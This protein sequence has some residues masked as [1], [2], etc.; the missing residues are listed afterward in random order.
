MMETAPG[1]RSRLPLKLDAFGA[2]DIGRK[3]KHNEDAVLLRPDLQL[4]VLADG[5]G[6]HNAGNV[7]SALA[8][9]SVANFFE[10][11]EE[12]FKALPLIDQF[13]LSVG[14]R[15]L[16]AAVQRAN[17]DIIDIS[18][19][20]NKHKGMGSTVVA[21]SISAAHGIAH[22]AHVGDSPCY[23]I[24]G[25]ELEQLTVDHSLLNDVLET[26]PDVDDVSLARLPR[27]VVTRALGMEARVRVSVRSHNVLTGDRYLLCS[28]GLTNEL[29]DDQIAE[30]LRLQKPAE[31]QVRLLL[32]LALE[33]GAEDNLAALVLA[34]EVS[35]AAS[36]SSWPKR[37]TSQRPPMITLVDSAEGDGPD[38]GPEIV[39]VGVENLPD[40]VPPGSANQELLEALQAIRFAKG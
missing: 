1:L 17:R 6:G 40:V 21:L 18:K 20:S 24:R 27:H 7:A 39:I 10:E 11:T 36:P 38:T 30:V 19:T 32:D 4:Y 12:S 9:T 33:S 29:E 34:C 28:D 15:R 5:A 3:R 16:V 8:T 26:R 35:P 37:R 23:R 25:G 13:G 31:A 22:V 14:E 2:V